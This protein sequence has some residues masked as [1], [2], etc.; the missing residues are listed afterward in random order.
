VRLYNNMANQA[1][2]KHGVIIGHIAV[3]FPSKF[4][5]DAFN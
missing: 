4:H 1:A 3:S 2:D 5:S